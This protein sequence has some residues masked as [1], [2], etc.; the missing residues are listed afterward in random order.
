MM[1]DFLIYNLKVSMCLALLYVAYKLMSRGSTHHLFNRVLL[2]GSIIISMIIPLVSI[3]YVSDATVV[4]PQFVNISNVVI[5]SSVANITW[6]GILVLLFVIGAGASGIYYLSSLYNTWKIIRES[7]QYLLANK[8]VLC[9]TSRN[10]LPFNWFRYVVLTKNDYDTPQ[11][12]EILLHEQAHMRLYHTGEVS[13]LRL[14]SCIQ[15]YNPI[16]WLIMRDIRAIHEYQADEAVLKSG[17]DAKKYQLLLIGRAVTG[18]C[19]SCANSF[20]QVKL[21]KRIVMMLKKRST[22]WAYL[23]SLYIVPAIVAA[24]I[25]FSN[26]ACTS[27]ETSQPMPDGDGDRVESINPETLIFANNK[28]ITKEEMAKILPDRIGSVHVWKGEDAIAKYGDKAK[29]GAI[30]I[31]LK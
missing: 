31:T 6:Q 11:C 29:Y 1:Y 2:C 20:S 28:L 25:S 9:I 15:W 23:K 19:I 8:S 18:R 5:A 17:I 16:M 26:V 21:K 13:F 3:Y 7:K 24:M 27:T 30:E 12:D 10:I 14:L 22:K 4:L